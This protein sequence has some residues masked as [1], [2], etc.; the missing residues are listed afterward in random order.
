M[1]QHSGQHLLS[2]VL[3]KQYDTQVRQA[4]GGGHT[5]HQNSNRASLL[6]PDSVLVDG[7]AHRGQGGR[8]LHRGGQGGERGGPGRGA[9]ALQRGHQGRAPRHRQHLRGRGPGAGPGASVTCTAAC[10]TAATCQAH[11]RGLPSDHVGPVRV[12]SI[13]GVDTNLCCGTHVAATSQLQM[14][15]L[16]GLESKVSDVSWSLGCLNI[17]PTEKQALPLLPGRRPGVLL[18]QGLCREREDADKAPEQR[19]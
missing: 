7:G 6:L 17:S 14:L 3:E 16:M 4:E 12:V 9:G 10:H 19:P 1:Q 13:P 2:A 18:P 8:V 5:T 15:H 11:T